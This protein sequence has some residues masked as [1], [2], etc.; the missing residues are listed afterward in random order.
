MNNMNNQKMLP[1]RFVITILTVMMISAS[2]SNKNGET[3]AYGN[4]E[5]DEVIISAQAQ[6][7][8]LSVEVAEGSNVEKG[9]LICTIDSTLPMIKQAQLLA[10]QSVINARLKNLAAQLRVQEEQ[11]INLAREVERTEKLFMD[12][13]ATQQQFDEITGKLK[14][15]DL[16]TEAIRSQKSIIQ[17]EKLVLSAQLDELANTLAKCHV[18]SPIKGTVL[19]QYVE[20]GELV[21]PGKNLIKLANVEEMELRVYISGS[22]LSSIAIGDSATIFIDSKDES[23]E[24]MRGTVSWIASQVEFTPKIIQT[25]EERI[26]MVYAVKIRVRNEGR[27]KIGMPGEVAFGKK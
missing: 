20:S 19:E 1:A 18:I 23:L 3:D 14:V 13:A 9:Q 16:Q 25:R 17:G 15:L 21:N 2:C 6:G 22:Q 7:E 12:H 24:L 26:N 5:A 27:L 10:Q 11:R 4:F 8:I